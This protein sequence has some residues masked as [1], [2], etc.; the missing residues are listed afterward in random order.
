M[1]EVNPLQNLTEYEGRFICYGDFLNITLRKYPEYGTP[2]W[3][4]HPRGSK[5]QGVVFDFEITENALNATVLGM[6]LDNVT[7][8]EFSR[9]KFEY[10]KAR[11][12]RFLTQIRLLICPQSH[13]GF[14]LES[15]DL[16]DKF[17]S[18]F[19][20]CRTQAQ[21]SSS[22]VIVPPIANQDFS[23][24]RLREFEHDAADPKRMSE[25]IDAVMDDVEVWQERIKKLTRKEHHEGGEGG[26]KP[27]YELLWKGYTEWGKTME[28]PAATSERLFRS[29]CVRRQK[30]KRNVDDDDCGMW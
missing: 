6:K 12:E 26:T 21:A 27:E 3:W 16:T 28:L 7:W 1:V 5:R 24:A 15:N 18:E 4:Q 9:E 11:V 17:V 19:V 20:I 14:H 13:F 25:S 23:R 2:R 29:A 22:S 30:R 10:R 8:G